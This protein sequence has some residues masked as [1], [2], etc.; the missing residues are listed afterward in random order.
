MFSL[1][2]QSDLAIPLAG[3]C[4]QAGFPSPADDYLEGCIDLNRELVS[5]KE[6]TFYARVRGSSM[7]DIGIREG[8]VLVVDRSVLP[9]SGDLA[10][11][12]VNGEFT[13]KRYVEQNGRVTLQAEN[14]AFSP[15]EVRRQDDFMVWGVV[16][17]TIHK[18]R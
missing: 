6:A 12:C 5:N 15:I 14:R 3:A 8:D 13:L 11:C 2:F 1:N 10:V 17:Y 4:V 16:T 7:K 9:R 18:R